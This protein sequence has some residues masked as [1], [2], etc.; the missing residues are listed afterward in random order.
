MVIAFKPFMVI[1]FKPFKYII[2]KLKYNK[3]TMISLLYKLYKLNKI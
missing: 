2:I 1:A 3:D